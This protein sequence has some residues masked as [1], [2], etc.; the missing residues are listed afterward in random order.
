MLFRSPLTFQVGSLMSSITSG[1]VE[2]D[3]YNLYLTETGTDNTTY[4]SPAS[5]V[6][7]TLA[8]TD[9]TMLPNTVTYTAAAAVQASATQI[10]S[11]VAV[12]NAT[13]NGTGTGASFIGSISGTALTVTSVTSGT[14]SIGQYL[15]GTGIT[16]GT[17]I[18]AGSGTSWTVDTSQTVTAGTVFYTISGVSLPPAITGRRVVIVNQTGYPI[19]VYPQQ[20]VS[21]NGTGTAGSTTI[22]VTSTS[23]LYVGM[24]EQQA[25]NIPAGARII[26]ILSSSTFAISSPVTTGFTTQA[27][28]FSNAGAT[29][30]NGMTVNTGYVVAGT[31]SVELTATSTTA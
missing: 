1:G 12:V 29:A 8:Y 24:V 18:T 4:S 11:D 21:M 15:N 5:T 14:I 10:Y 26:S 27:L 25:S 16:A 23:G 20:T 9:T 7:R 31:T 2:W 28:T 19:I 17:K 13:S 22:S 30:I 3:G 6:R